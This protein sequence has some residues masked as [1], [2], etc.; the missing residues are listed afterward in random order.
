MS[1]LRNIC[2]RALILGGAIAL[3][4]GFSACSGIYFNTTFNAEKAYRQAIDM[5]AKRLRLNPDDTVSVTAD[6]KAKLTRAVT[7]SSKVLELWPNDP[8]YTPRAVFRIAECQLLMGD[9]GN[10]AFKYGEYIRYFPKAD[11]IPLARVR[12]AKALYLDGKRLS[13][14]DALAEVQATHPQGEVKREAL[15]LA[16]RMRIDDQSGAEGLE[17]Y[18]EL[19]K[20]N[21]LLASESRSELHWRAAQLAYDLGQW[22]KARDHAIAADNSA[23]PARVRFRNQRLAV[24]ALYGL[25]RQKEGLAEV[26]DM[27]GKREFRV[28]RP[29][30]KLLEA[31]GV[32]SQGLAN[33]PAASKL[34]RETVRLGNRRPSAAEAWYRIGAHVLDVQNREDSAKV[35]F[36][37][38]SA[39]GSSFEFGTLGADYSSALGRLADLRTVDSVTLAAQAETRWLLLHPVDSLALR[40][41]LL[42]RDS[43]LHADSL[44]ALA[45]KDA[46]LK[47]GSK[48][49]SDKTAAA[50]SVKAA[51]EAAAK[52]AKVQKAPSPQYAP[53][54]IA[55]LFHFRL[56]KP[57]SAH[58]FLNRIVSDTLED[59]LYTRRAI[60]A[61][62]W[63]EEN[64][65][66]NK[67]RAD[68]LYRV[69]LTRYPE[70]EW[71]KQAEKNLELPPTVQTP[72]DK[73]HTLFLAAENRRFAGED[74]KTRVW[75]AY[76]I[77]AD[78]F[79]QSRDAAKALFTVAFTEEQAAIAKADTAK[80]DTVRA[81]YAMV[82]D[83]F[84]GTPQAVAAES[85]ISA[86]EAAPASSGSSTETPKSNREE[87]ADTQSEEDTNGPPKVELLDP[88]AEQDLY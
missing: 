19:L 58:V 24:L 71:A 51:K 88:A 76:R 9:Y 59:T 41:S 3:S 55:E 22:Q 14:R 61:L 42:A 5:R 79:P 43:I 7:K 32:E 13:A 4:T 57:D 48:K 74:L 10:A 82:R 63:L 18:E 31:R 52:V 68:S 84:P 72:D 64:Q 81:A 21:A 30:I 54:L 45:K 87:E 27:W 37:S 75:P 62:A 16:A 47:K 77:V 33:W 56:P 65:Y 15:L 23:L 8:K 1:R 26:E 28:F 69:L 29:D 73:A 44:N 36:D 25:G 86:V 6:E 11:N 38:A 34:Y 46:I 17:L 20:D 85:W 78:S 53:F 80:V 12:M 35:Y 40:D 67:N 66:H 50:D 83:K 2:R 49:K 39:A 70:T 60:Y